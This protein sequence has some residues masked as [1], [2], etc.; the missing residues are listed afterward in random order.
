[1]R[2]ERNDADEPQQQNQDEENDVAQTTAMYLYAV[3]IF[4]LLSCLSFVIG[5]M[6]V[7]VF[8]LFFLNFFPS[9]EL[10][11]PFHSIAFDSMF[12]CFKFFFIYLLVWFTTNSCTFMSQQIFIVITII[13]VA[14]LFGVYVL[15]P[16]CFTR[17]KKKSRFLTKR[18]VFANIRQHSQHTMLAEKEKMQFMIQTIPKLLIWITFI[19]GLISCAETFSIWPT[20]NCYFYR[21]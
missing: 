3:C 16:W 4:F 1:M 17:R 19:Y 12:I 5:S 10:V 9:I 13:L 6:S 18:W 21:I 8:F 7:N 2:W 15:F 14:D 20:N 11:V